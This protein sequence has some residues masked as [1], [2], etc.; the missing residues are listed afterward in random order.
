MSETVETVQPVDIET[1]REFCVNAEFGPW[2]TGDG[3]QLKGCDGRNLLEECDDVSEFKHE[4][5]AAFC[6]AA[7]TLLPQALDEIGRLRAELDYYIRALRI[8]A[9]YRS[10]GK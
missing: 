7:R 5:N 2:T 9:G 3:W 6:A 1:A 8:N 4:S 10:E